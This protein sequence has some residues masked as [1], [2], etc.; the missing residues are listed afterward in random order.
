MS[1][2]ALKSLKQRTPL[3]VIGTLVVWLQTLTPNVRAAEQCGPSFGNNRS[4]SIQFTVYHGLIYRGMPDLEKLGISRVRII[5]RGVLTNDSA[6]PQVDP[7]RVEALLASVPKD[8]TPLVLDFEQFHT[9]GSAATVNRSVRKLNEIAAAFRHALPGRRIGHYGAIPIRDYWRAIKLDRSNAGFR[10]WQEENN[11]LAG[12]EQ[13]VDLLFPSLYTF[14]DD[15]EGWQRYAI[16]QICEAR[17]ISNK[18][19]IAFLWP[20]YHDSNQR[21]RDRFLPGDYWQLQL[22]TAYRY[23]DGVVIWG[24]YDLQNRRPRDWDD[25]AEWWKRTKMFLQDPPMRK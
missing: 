17:R 16:A 5:D 6:E 18:P 24:G 13:Q 7:A 8:Q 11:Q 3:V 23:A 19:V 21:V 15:R 1:T 2:R 14:Y 4:G 20:E 25:N 22:E 10:A 9:T 12:L